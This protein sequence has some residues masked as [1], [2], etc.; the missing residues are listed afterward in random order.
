MNLHTVLHSGCINLH[1]HQQWKRAPFSPHFLQHL[2]FVDSLMMAI[3]TGF[4]SGS[5]VKNLP[6]VQETRVWSLGRE[7]PLEEGMATHSSVLAWRIPWTEEPGR[8]Q[9]TGSQR[10]GH[11][12]SDL[13]GTHACI[14]TGMRWHHIF[15]K[16]IL[17]VSL[18]LWASVTSSLRCS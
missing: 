4:P 18:P 6:V 10:V 9:S 11:D 1:S 17:Q 12:W 8:L 16:L 3:V 15:K 13:A 14:L 2:L 5:T 7:D